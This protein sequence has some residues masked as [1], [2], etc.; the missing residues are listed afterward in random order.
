MPWAHNQE[1]LLSSRSVSASTPVL[2]HPPSE[3]FL[4]ANL[5][6]SRVCQCASS[7]HICLSFPAELSC[8]A[9]GSQ[10]PWSFSSSTAFPDGPHVPTHLSSIHPHLPISIKTDNTKLRKLPLVGPGLASGVTTSSQ[11]SS[12][13]KAECLPQLPLPCLWVSY[14][15][16]L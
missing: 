14:I 15:S 8:P 12:S 5:Q 11:V 16:S 10:T 9:L 2:E 13:A 4:P 3:S 1:L 6:P 7:P